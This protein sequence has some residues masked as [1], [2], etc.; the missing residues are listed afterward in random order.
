MTAAPRFGSMACVLALA[1]GG[2]GQAAAPGAPDNPGSAAPGAPAPPAAP[3]DAAE[4]PAPAATRVALRPAGYDTIRIGAAPST[5]TGYSLTDDRSYDDGCRIYL[6]SR[7]PH[8]YA[9]V[10]NGVVMRIT[11][12]GDESGASSV[13]TDRGIGVGSTEA[14]VRAAFAPLREEPHHYVEAPAKD[15]FFGGTEEAPGLRFEIGADGR[16]SSLHAGLMP[17]LGYVEG[18]S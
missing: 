2:C 8:F 7:L 10:E 1:V 15:L 14:E 4:S 17:T 16:V 12:Y 3:D 13:R 9:I 6:S 11:A 5:A 18:C